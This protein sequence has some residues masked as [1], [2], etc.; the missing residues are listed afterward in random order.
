MFE[1]RYQ[2]KASDE[3]AQVRAE[4]NSGLVR[5]G[6]QRAQQLQAKPET[7]Y[8]QSRQSHCVQDNA[9]RYQHQYAC[10]RMQQQIGT[11]H[12][13]DRTTCA[14]HRNHR[15]WVWQRMC[16]HGDDTAHEIENNE[17]HMPHAVFY[18]IAEDP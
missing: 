13:G 15:V 10:I 4:G 16:K 14:N 17:P 11:E 12:T 1:Q 7:Q 5:I 2:C 18:V 6:H 8:R 9:E 3:A